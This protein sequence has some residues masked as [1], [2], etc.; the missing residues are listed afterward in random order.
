MGTLEARFNSK[1]ME[2]FSILFYLSLAMLIGFINIV[3]EA[4]S[5]VNSLRDPVWD[6]GIVLHV[7]I[8][9]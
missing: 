7:G 8:I 5:I 6:L 9:F 3:Y 4:N 1:R 2:K